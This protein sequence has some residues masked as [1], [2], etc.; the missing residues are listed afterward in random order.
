MTGTEAAQVFKGVVVEE[1][2]AAACASSFFGSYKHPDAFTNR[3][4]DSKDIEEKQKIK[5]A[6]AKLSLACL[7]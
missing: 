5:A 2:Q 1:M 6:K 7:I 3:E 4:D